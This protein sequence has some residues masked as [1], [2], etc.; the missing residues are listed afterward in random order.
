MAAESRATIRPEK[1]NG[2]RWWGAL[3]ILR[4]NLFA[5]FGQSALVA[6]GGVLVDQ[7]LAR[8]TIEKLDRGEPFL[9]G[10]GAGSPLDRG[11]K[12]RSLGAIADCGG[13]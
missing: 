5:G 13:A 8:S 12:R 7:S 9:G 4:R 2:R 11:A 1:K 3:L 10:S 6:R